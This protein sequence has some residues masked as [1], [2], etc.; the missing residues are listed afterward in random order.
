MKIIKFDTHKI[1]LKDSF[2]KIFDTDTL[3]NIHLLHTKD[4]F[5][6]IFDKN[7]DNTTEYHKIFNNNKSLFDH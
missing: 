3:E 5:R 6:D 1:H 2:K 4:N 7:N